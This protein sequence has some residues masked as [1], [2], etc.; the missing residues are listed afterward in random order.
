MSITPF[1]APTTLPT[2]PP[3]IPPIGPAAALPSAAPRSIPSKE[4]PHF[5]HDT[6]T[7]HIPF[8]EE[9]GGRFPDAIIVGID[10]NWR[11]AIDLNKE[12]EGKSLKRDDKFN[13]EIY[14]NPIIIKQKLN[15]SSGSLSGMDL[16]SSDSSSPPIPRLNEQR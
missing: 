3:T 7:F 2:T 14:M 8:A 16:G 11:T 13:K 10:E 9:I 6:F 12:R 4:P 15:S 1:A 5:V